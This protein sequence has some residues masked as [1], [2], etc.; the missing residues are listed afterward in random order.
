MEHMPDSLHNILRS[1]RRDK[2]QMS[3]IDRKIYIFQIFKAFAYLQVL[4]VYKVGQE[5]LP[6]RSQA[7][8]H[9]RQPYKSPS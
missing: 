1:L 6:S 4:K 8:K 3:D 9:P 5:N 2:K 7:S